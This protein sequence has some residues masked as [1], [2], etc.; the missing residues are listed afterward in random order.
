[1]SPDGLLISAP[2][3]RSL[4][5]TRSST[6]RSAVT[7]PPKAYSR[8]T[9][10]LKIMIWE[11][12]CLSRILSLWPLLISFY[13]HLEILS[14]KTAISILLTKRK[15]PH[16]LSRW[17]VR[18]CETQWKE[19]PSLD[20]CTESW[21]Q[22]YGWLHT[23]FFVCYVHVHFFCFWVNFYPVFLF[24]YVVLLYRLI[25]PLDRRDIDDL[26]LFITAVAL[27]KSFLELGSRLFETGRYIV[28]PFHCC[29]VAFF[30]YTGRR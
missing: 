16:Y 30:Q 23:R 7:T 26:S 19:K 27:S 12:A 2:V 22:H 3:A 6:S 10:K 14:F 18:K 21:N 5:L 20:K 11:G 28:A 25:C 4:L 13:K 8:L 24:Y 17:L 29:V 15:S 1:M 9:N